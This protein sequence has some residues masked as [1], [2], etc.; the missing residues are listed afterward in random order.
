M[1]AALSG[2]GWPYESGPNEM[3]IAVDGGLSGVRSYLTEDRS[4]E[5][6]DNALDYAT[7][8]QDLEVLVLLVEAGADPAHQDN[9]PALHMLAIGTKDNVSVAEYLVAEGA[10]PCETSSLGSGQFESFSEFAAMRGQPA[11]SAFLAEQESACS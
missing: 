8:R 9:R 10:D 4:Q 2:C 11:I 3:S 7:R 1:S 6:L 5:E